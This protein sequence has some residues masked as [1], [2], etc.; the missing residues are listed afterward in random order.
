MGKQRKKDESWK[1][2]FSKNVPADSQYHY[3]H[4]SHT[5]T[6][7][8]CPHRIALVNQGIYGCWIGRDPSTCFTGC[9]YME[10]HEVKVS[11]ASITTG[12][13]GSI[14]FMNALEE[15]K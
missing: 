13:K 5:E 9:P 6:Q 15:E 14:A 1:R 3:E 7:K 2:I 10:E 8:S 12:E 11:Y 4:G